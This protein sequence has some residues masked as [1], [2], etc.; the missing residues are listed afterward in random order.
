MTLKV[1]RAFPELDRY[2]DE[3]CRR[4]IRAARRGVRSWWHLFLYIVVFHVGLGIAGGIAVAAFGYSEDYQTARRADIWWVS[5][6]AFLVAVP[7][8]AIVPMGV[9][10]MRDVL[11]RRR[12]RWVLKTQSACP[13]CRYGLIGLAVSPDNT[14]TCPEC[15]HAAAVDPSLGELTLDDQGRQ[16]YIPAVI[17]PQRI[18]WTRQRLKRYG[19]RAAIALGCLLL[20]AGVYEGFLRIQAGAARAA[21]PGREALAALAATVQPPSSNPAADNAW[22]VFNRAQLLRDEV[23]ERV[24]RSNPTQI[25]G[26]DVY[27]DST[28]LYFTP[29]VTVEPFDQAATD[30]GRRMLDEYRT[31]G[32]FELLDGV[33]ALP[34]TERAI[35]V[36]DDD[37]LMMAHLEYLGKVR[38]FTRDNYARMALAAQA[39]DHREFLSA[40]ESNLALARLCATQP[41]G[42]GLLMR[43][44]I[45]TGTYTQLRRLLKAHPPEG[46]LMAIRS[47][48]DR[49]RCDLPVTFAIEGERIFALDG[50]SVFFSDLS[51]V[52][53]GRFSAAESDWFD[54]AFSSFSGRVGTF[55]GNRAVMNR[56]YD[57]AVAAAA[58][59]P[60]GR[61]TGVALNP[62]TGLALPDLLTTQLGHLINSHD[63]N[64][65]SREGH[66]LL[67][68]LE[69]YYAANQRY[70]AELG[71]LV[72]AFLPALPRD[73]VSGLAW[74][75]VVVDPAVDVRDRHFL[76]YGFGADGADDSGAR[77]SAAGSIFTGSFGP[78][79][80]PSPGSDVVVNED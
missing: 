27:P 48:M 21:R 35:I 40:F 7:A 34:R 54:S 25:D 73:P 42:I 37:P 41:T 29:Q 61:P 69:R 52:R 66:L 19:K 75:Y 76:L 44:A 50:V 56:I 10:L 20:I 38:Q 17:Q 23:D 68:A 63:I 28:Y 39:G 51:N 33:A 31:A 80:E 78:L 30:L 24:W 70:P 59:R 77:S 74:G 32:V 9:L 5:A 14:I 58:M 15:G 36:A 46:T 64:L 72:P 47:A 67:V 26:R 3:Q 71:E 8:V 2:S 62:S 22:T 12:V 79:F 57:N 49:Q 11:L 18:F 53:F 55:W 6:L 60:P 43:T 13:S 4:F 45:E 16:Q 1:Y 65:W